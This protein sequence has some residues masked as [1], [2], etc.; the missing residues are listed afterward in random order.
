[1][2]TK[3]LQNSTTYVRCPKDEHHPYNIV[4]ASLY[5]LNGNQ[6]AIMAQIIC[7]SDE[8]VIVKEEIRSRVNISRLKFDTA[9]QSLIDMGYI[10]M[11]RIQAGHHYTIYEDPG[12]ST[13]TGGICENSTTTTGTTCAGGILTNTN[14]NYYSEVTATTGGTCDEG[15]FNELLNLYPSRG[16]RAD[17]TNYNLKSKIK[18]CKQGYLEY[19]R[20]NL[21][22]HEEIMTALKVELNDRQMTGNTHYQQ[23][24]LRW[25]EDKVFEQYKGRVLEP[26]KLVYGTEIS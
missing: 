10:V 20:S 16:T 11:R 22:T 19:L 25:I 5:L 6:F 1:M 9:W 4:P 26:F 13:T 2:G 23:G 24:L 12:S 17:G 15:Q 3:K 21:L 7:N 18:E 8:W 14:N